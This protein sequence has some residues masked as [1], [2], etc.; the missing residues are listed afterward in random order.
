ML[1]ENFTP[2][3]VSDGNEFTHRHCADACIRPEILLELREKNW[4]V[5]LECGLELK[6]ESEGKKLF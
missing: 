1:I 3:T 4:Q 5:F 2:K 6:S